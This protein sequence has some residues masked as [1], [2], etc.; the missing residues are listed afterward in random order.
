M[1][2][3]F[4]KLQTGDSTLQRI[5]DNIANTL[6]PIT[7]NPLINAQILPGI[8]LKVGPNVINHGLGRKLQGWSILR[9]RVV[10]S[11]VFDTQ[12]TNLT[13]DKTLLLNSSVLVTVDLEVF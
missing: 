3:Q 4:S 1:I 2:S 12:D 10:F 9:M 11:Q 6:N 7:Q 13:P 5:Q 8:V